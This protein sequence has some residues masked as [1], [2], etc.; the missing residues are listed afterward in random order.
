ML[1]KITN[2]RVSVR[3]QK[4]PF[5]RFCLA[6]LIEFVLTG[7]DK[8]LHASI[9]LY[10][11]KAL[12]NSDHGVLLVKMKYFGFGTSIIK[13]FESYLSSRKFLFYIDNDFSEDGTLTLFLGCSI[14]ECM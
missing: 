4:K 9:T 5:S 12:D 14:I 2:V 1:K 6:Q 11:Q 10:L 8:Q 7:M 13:R 3:L